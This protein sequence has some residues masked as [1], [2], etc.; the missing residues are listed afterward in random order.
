M[1]VGTFARQSASGKVEP[2]RFC[3]LHV[4]NQ[5]SFQKTKQQ[6]QKPNVF[7]LEEVAVMAGIVF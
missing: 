3:L 7:C 6:M 5:P 4:K 2:K 1:P